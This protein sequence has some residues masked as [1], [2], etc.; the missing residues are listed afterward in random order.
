MSVERVYALFG[1]PELN[2]GSRKGFD[3]Q[4]LIFPD[5]T[6]MCSGEVVKWI[7]GGDWN[8]DDQDEYLPSSLS[9][10][11]TPRIS[12]GW[13]GRGGSA[14]Y[15]Y[16]S[17]FSLLATDMTVLFSFTYVLSPESLQIWSS[18]GTWKWRAEL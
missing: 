11:S 14:V 1:I 12:P 13:N 4:Q 5:I 17:Y 9:G 16:T 18:G 10:C 6:F 8:G 7:M 15:S 3:G 2:K